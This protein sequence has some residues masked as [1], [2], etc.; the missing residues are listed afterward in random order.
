MKS[1]INHVIPKSCVY[2]IMMA[3]KEAGRG[4]KCKILTPKREQDAAKAIQAIQQTQY[5]K[6]PVA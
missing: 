3:S 5:L 1:F 4:G 6:I 2:R